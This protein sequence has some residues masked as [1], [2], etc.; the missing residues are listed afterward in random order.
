LPCG[1]LTFVP[2]RKCDEQLAPIVKSVI[3][4]AGRV[5]IPELGRIKDQLVSKYGKEWN[6]LAASGA[7]QRLVLKLGIRNPDVTLVN[8]YLLAIAEIY[9][10]PWAPVEEEDL[11]G[12]G[13]APSPVAQ[14]YPPMSPQPAALGCDAPPPYSPAVASIGGPPPAQ[15]H[16]TQSSTL[17]QPTSAPSN[18]PS[19]APS[20]GFDEL[21]KRFEALKGKK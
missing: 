9:G 16:H 13:Q 8:R 21:A 19:P 12:K 6:E 17:S 15:Y 10:I 14:A 20:D 4:A 1:L 11:I 7:D 5:D 2:C 3:F 18:T